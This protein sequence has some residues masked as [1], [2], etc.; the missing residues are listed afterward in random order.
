MTNELEA[1]CVWNKLDVSV[2]HAHTNTHTVRRVR[3]VTIT[4]TDLWMDQAMPKRLDAGMVT[5]KRRKSSTSPAHHG[6]SSFASRVVRRF[7]RVTLKLRHKRGDY[8]NLFFSPSSN[9]SLIN[10]S[11]LLQ[12]SRKLSFFRS[13]F[14]WIG[15]EYNEHKNYWVSAVKCHLTL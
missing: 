12:C 9:T 11:L 1:E 15:V 8:R 14:W 2:R 10:V 3:F 7:R 13:L 5:P 4:L 6:M